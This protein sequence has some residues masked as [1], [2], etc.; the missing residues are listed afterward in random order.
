VAKGLNSQKGKLTLFTSQ[1]AHSLSTF[2]DKW[3]TKG[4]FKKRGLNQKRKVPVTTLDALI[5]RYGRPKFCKIDVEGFELPV[6]KG[7]TTP[8]PFLS[9]E[10]VEE[11]LDEAKLCARHLESLGEVEFN[12]FLYNT[13]H[14]SSDNWLPSDQL[15]SKLASLRGLFLCGDIYAR[16]S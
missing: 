13:Y 12:Y 3:R 8:V 16:F 5:D 6:L 9:F 11:F 4:R 10:F 14:F 1:K 7:L 15:F 2:S